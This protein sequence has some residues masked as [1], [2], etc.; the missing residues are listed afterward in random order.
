MTLLVFYERPIIRAVRENV[1]LYDLI[2]GC[3]V[4]IFANATCKLGVIGI[5]TRINNG[6][7]YVVT[8]RPTP[9]VLHVEVIE[10]SLQLV[11]L[12]AYA[13]LRTCGQTFTISLVLALGKL[14][15]LNLIVQC[16]I[17][18]IFAVTASRINILYGHVTGQSKRSKL[19]V[20]RNAQLG[21]EFFSQCLRLPAVR[22]VEDN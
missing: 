2:L 6:N 21:S 16:H 19:A 13:I 5:N 14:T 1:V 15:G 4:G 3:I 8:G 22:V 7:R 20:K 11:V 10:I 12:I 17:R 9:N 18:N